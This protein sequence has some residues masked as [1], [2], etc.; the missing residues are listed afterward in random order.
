MIYS[1]P[2]IAAILWGICYALI[3]AGLKNISIPTLMFMFGTSTLFAAIL[4]HNF[5]AEK[6]NFVPLVDTKLLII[7]LGAMIASALANIAIYQS[8][9]IFGATYSAFGEV[10]YPIFV[11]IFIWLLFGNS[12]INLSTIIGGIIIISGVYVMIY[13]QMSNESERD[14]K[15]SEIEL[16]QQPKIENI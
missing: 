14:I 6:I 1:L 7:C 15:L 4:F 12:N 11:P 16:S 9:K 10:L 13:G 8:V 5:S 2:I 3:E